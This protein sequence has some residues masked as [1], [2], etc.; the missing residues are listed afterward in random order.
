MQGVSKR[1]I[2]KYISLTNPYLLKKI[3]IKNFGMNT[4]L[5]YLKKLILVIRMFTTTYSVLKTAISHR[6]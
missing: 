2:N 1:C 3:E 4:L 6:K 5:K